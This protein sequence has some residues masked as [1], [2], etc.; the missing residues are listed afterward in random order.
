MQRPRRPCLKKKLVIFGVNFLSWSSPFLGLG[1]FFPLGVLFAFPK[2]REVRS[3]A[4][5]SLL[6]QIACWIV[7]YPLEVSA[8]L[9]PVVEN[10]V[11][12]LVLDL[13]EWLIG[14][15]VLIGLL[16]LI[17][18]SVYLKIRRKRKSKSH[19]KVFVPEEKIERIHYKILVLLV[20]G[21]LTSRLVFQDP[22]RLEYGQLG[23]LEDS[24]LYFFSVLIAGDTFL[25]RGKQFFL[26]RRSWKLFEKQNRVAR[27]S[28][29]RGKWGLLKRKYSKLRDWI[30]PGWGHIYIGNL[31]KGFSILF[32]YLL[33]LLFF[34]TAFFSWLEPAD[35]IRFLMSMGLKPGIRDQTFFK[36]TSS[37]IP[38]LIFLGGMIGI[39]L[40][41][42]FLLGKAFHSEPDDATPRSTFISNLSYSVLFHLILMSLVLIIPVTLQRKNKQ[43]ESER[44]RTHFTPEN[45]EFYFIDPNLPSEVEG[46]NG[47][48]VSGTETPTQK[49][50]EKIPEDKPAEEGRVKGEVKQVRGKKLPSTYSNY[51]SA[52]MRGPESFMEYWRRAPRNYSSVVAYTVTPDGEVVD[53][54]LVEASGYPEQDQMT[55]ELI[56]SLSPLMPPP[57][58]KGYVRVTELFWNGSIDPE[59]MP[60]PLQKELVT[61]YDGRY[62]E[63]L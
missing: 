45:L 1:I 2:G 56:E 18:H 46:L 23:I 50:G 30:F 34:A 25:S 40:I 3:S 39:Q 36:I 4:F 31:W 60:T 38:I 24:F 33:L 28:D 35:G 59:A 16:V 63:E 32:L 6:F 22:Y 10:F 15:Y 13:R 49:E 48:V 17:S 19:S 26:F 14:F 54:D 12:T 62:M 55:L 21:Y 20:A 43:K 5:G 51:I 52:K 61:M 41:S 27:R 9:F 47:G 42:K 29:F 57:G 44:Q 11:R 53:V 37:V 7:L 58:T 8:I